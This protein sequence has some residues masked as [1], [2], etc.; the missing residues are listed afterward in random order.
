MQS[1][2]RASDTK[3]GK[4]QQIT[5]LKRHFFSRHIKKRAQV[6]REKSLCEF[7][8]QNVICYRVIWLVRDRLWCNRA[9][10]VPIKSCQRESQLRSL[11]QGEGGVDRA[12]LSHRR[13]FRD[14]DSPGLSVFS[15]SSS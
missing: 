12:G 10:S 11:D 9:F 2:M 5:D 15:Q 8:V 6:E 7:I 4:D 3:V 1:D 14:L 13:G